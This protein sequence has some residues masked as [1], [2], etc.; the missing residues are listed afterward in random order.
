MADDYNKAKRTR[1]D[2]D[3]DV[4]DLRY[5]EAPEIS[6]ERM[7]ALLGDLKQRKEDRKKFQRHRADYDDAD[8]GYINTDNKQF[9]K[10][11]DRAFGKY[12]KDISS[13]LENG[14]A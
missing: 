12:T 6:K 1:D 9:V 4:D 2:L 10:K 3:R 14:T 8:V 7:D 13:A 5:G 11:I